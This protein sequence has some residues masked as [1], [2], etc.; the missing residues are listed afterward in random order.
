[1]ENYLNIRSYLSYETNYF[2]SFSEF[3]NIKNNVNNNYVNIL[4]SNIKSV[5]SKCWR[6]NFIFRKWDD[7]KKIDIIVLTEVWHNAFIHYNYTIDSYNLFY[8]SIRRN[9]NNGILILSRIMNVLILQCCVFFFYFF[10]VFVTV[11]TF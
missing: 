10:F 7:S 8:S 6:I 5:N 1:M 2:K 4:C 9:Q 3:F 11:I